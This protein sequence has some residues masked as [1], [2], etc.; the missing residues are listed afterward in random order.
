VTTTTLPQP[1]GGLYGWLAA[2][3]HKRIALMTMAAGLVFFVVSGANALL[4]RLELARPGEQ[5]LS[6]DTFNE[7]F[8]M[9]GAGMVYLFVTPVALA[10]GLYMV[11]LQVGA[12]QVMAPRLALFGFWI[13]VVGGVILQSAWLTTDGPGKAGWTSYVP[14]SD[15][16]NT[17]GT[18]MDMFLLGVILAT[19]G[20][21]CF[22]ICILGTILRLRAPGMTMLR[23]PVFCW[24]MLVTSLMVVMSFPVLVVAEALLL[25]D[26][27]GAE[28]FS[29]DGGPIAYQN[30]FWFYG[31]PVVYVWF[32]PFLGVV[33]EVISVFSGRRLWGYRTLIFALLA[34]TALSM[35]VWAHHMFTTGQSNNEYFALTST[36]LLVPAGIEYLGLGATMWRGS[37]RLTTPMLFALAFA[38]QFLIGGLTGIMLGSPALD[39]QLHDSYFVVAHFHYTAFGGSLF[40]AF[41]AAYYWFPKMT[42]LVL[43]DGLG[44]LHFWLMVVGFNLT[45]FPMFISGWAGMPRRVADYSRTDVLE[46]ANLL[47]T[48]GGFVLTVAIIIFIANIVLSVRDRR[49]AAADPWGGF[50]L[51]WATSSPPPALNFRGPLPP[52]TSE[53]PVLDQRI[54]PPVAAAKP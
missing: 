54:G 15:A 22:G 26:R 23:L 46:T 51:E 42:G 2:A 9:H 4:V 10:I 18:G 17:P 28:V 48:I 39:Y 41:A 45:F 38:I 29:R 35:S 33:A 25:A 1:A 52:I 16:V 12:A 47:S 37:I 8:T 27:Y 7:A 43:R 21:L 19:A 40:G 34:F 11:P 36:L 31:H 44:K 3:D 53:T 5:V 50:T 20:G 24:T 6:R 32:F 49:P 14:L 30:L 13:Y